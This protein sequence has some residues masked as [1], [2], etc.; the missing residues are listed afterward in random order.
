MSHTNIYLDVLA[1]AL[2]TDDTSGP[3]AMETIKAIKTT[4]PDVHV[5]CGLSNVSFGLPKRV[6]L[7]NAFLAAAVFAGLDSVIIDITNASTK[8][9]LFASLAIAGKDEYC[10]NY[11]NSA[12]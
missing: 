8:Q 2:A 10:L 6:N 3:V 1:E 4:F 11:L 9:M 7:N 12:R 5:T